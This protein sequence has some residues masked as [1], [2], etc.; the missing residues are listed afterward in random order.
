MLLHHLVAIATVGYTP[1]KNDDASH[2]CLHSTCKTVG[3]VIWEDKENN[4]Q[5]KGVLSGSGVHTKAIH[6]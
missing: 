6:C 2:L 5:R 1:A 3:H 4:Q